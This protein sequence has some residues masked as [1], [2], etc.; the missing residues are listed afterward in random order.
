MNC[1]L[2]DKERVTNRCG[3]IDCLPC[4][5]VV[6]KSNRK[7][8]TTSGKELKQGDFVL[9]KRESNLNDWFLCHPISFAQIVGPV[10]EN[11]KTRPGLPYVKEGES[12]VELKV[13]PFAYEMAPLAEQGWIQWSP[14]EV[15]KIPRWLYC[16]LGLLWPL[17]KLTYREP[18]DGRVTDW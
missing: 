14:S 7:F 9:R 16:V 8:Y 10:I 17:L 12:W 6:Y 2:T 13:I 11:W 1:N 15:I 4:K 18:L 5:T 3:N